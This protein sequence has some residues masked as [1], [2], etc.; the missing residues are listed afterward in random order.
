MLCLS[1]HP[2]G[3][4]ERLVVFAAASLREAFEEAR[5]AFASETGA[6]TAF[7]F[8]GSQQLAAQ[9]RQGARA[10]VFASADETRMD[11]LILAKL[12]DAGSVKTIARNRLVAIQPQ[13]KTA[14]FRD[15]G[16]PGIKIVIADPAV[17]AGSYTRIVLENLARDPAFGDSFRRGFEAN[18][19]SLETSVR[20]VLAKVALGEADAGIV[21]RS[22]LHSADGKKV[23]AIDIPP[24][25][26]V[27]ALYPAAPL[28]DAPHPAL[29][30]RFVDFLVSDRG[31]E[32][33]A[34]HGFE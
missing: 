14:S 12:V 19:V 16:N 5:A 1:A 30:G 8:A 21:Y 13:G 25:A 27:E 10:D 9:L 31:R 3:A 22:D 11:D 15:L 7:N 2:A 34:K 24:M 4:E 32:I 6:T 26:N 17:P 20:S 28:R 23:T 33:L 18:V 29:A